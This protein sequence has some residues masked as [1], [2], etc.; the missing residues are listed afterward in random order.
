MKRQN[1]SK[2]DDSNTKLKEAATKGSFPEELSFHAMEPSS[3]SVVSLP[4][5]LLQWLS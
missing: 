5:P 3:N 4:L 2:E 1:P